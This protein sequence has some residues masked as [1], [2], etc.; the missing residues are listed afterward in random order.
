[1]IHFHVLDYG[2]KNWNESWFLIFEMQVIPRKI[3]LSKTGRQLIQWPVKEIKMLRR[4][5][6]SL[7]HKEL[8]GRSTMEVLGGSASQVSISHGVIN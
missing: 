3:W 5:H 4:N 7:H 1:M 8:R 2:S 6:F